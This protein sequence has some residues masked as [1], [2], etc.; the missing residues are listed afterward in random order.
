MEKT[1]L[2]VGMDEVF[3]VIATERKYQKLV[4][5]DGENKRPLLGHI[6]LLRKYLNHDFSMHYANTEDNIQLGVPDACLHDLRKMATILVRAMEQYGA[7]ERKMS[8]T[9]KQ[10]MEG[11]EI[12]DN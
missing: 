2:K 4:W 6:E 5:P 7:P 12:N 11:G 10:L 9:E 1:E 8:E 3:S